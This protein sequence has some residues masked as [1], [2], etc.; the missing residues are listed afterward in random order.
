MTLFDILMKPKVIPPNGLK[1]MNNFISD[2]FGNKLYSKLNE[3]KEWFNVSKY[4]KSR[5]VLNFGY[6]YNY[7]HKGLGEKTTLFPDYIIELQHKIEDYL[8][9]TF[10]QCI[11]NKYEPGQSIGA[12]TDHT[13][14]FDNVIV[15]VSLNSGIEIEFKKGDKSFC[16]Y[17]K[18]NSLFVMSDECRY[19]WTH[20][21][22]KRRYDMVDNKKIERD[23]RISITFRKILC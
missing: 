1:Y 6:R 10:D 19:E 14:A 8:K 18:P 7:R 16:K 23:T 9:T 5:Q 13:V 3:E 2:E 15:C 4:P 20:E 17:L 12:H 11:V 21:I 22:K